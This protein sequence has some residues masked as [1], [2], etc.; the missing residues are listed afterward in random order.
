M[1]DSPRG[2]APDYTNA[3]VV[4]FGVNVTWVLVAIWAVWGFIAAM[5]MGYTLNH[6][7][8]RIAHWRA[9]RR[10]AAIRRG[11]PLRGDHG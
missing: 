5:L 6:L 11:K 1:S 2:S 7:L 4:M 9:L 3:C 8:D 10:A